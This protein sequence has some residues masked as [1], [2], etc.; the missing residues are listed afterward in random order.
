MADWVTVDQVKA[1]LGLDPADVTD[2]DW[3]TQ[4]TAA[5]NE[6]CTRRRVTAGY[7]DPDP[8]EDDAAKLGT[9]LYAMSLYRERGATD[10]FASMAEL[11]TF[12][13]AGG[14]WG[15]IQR[16]WGVNRPQV[17]YPDPTAVDPVGRRRRGW[18]W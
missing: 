2:D 13:P 12:V 15:Q 10:G 7:I 16:L 5:A 18:L 3:L 14:S 4:V 6:L 1:A 11:G 17:D 8:P 9:T